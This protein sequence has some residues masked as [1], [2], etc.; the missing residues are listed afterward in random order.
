M[1]PLEPVAV[2]RGR[3]A[4][5]K[6]KAAVAE[7]YHVQA[8]PPSKDYLVPVELRVDDTSIL[9]VGTP[10]YPPGKPHR[11]E[12]ETDPISTYEG[13]FEVLLPIDADLMAPEGEHM[14][15]GEMAY[16]ACDNHRCLFPASV[17][18]EISV[19]VT[20]HP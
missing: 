16:Q 19:R 9:H 4:H 14:L 11:I 5:V 15:K 18:V 2:A 7:G 10:L 6:I 8:N 3:I 20:A 12:G 1:A 17:P 13:T